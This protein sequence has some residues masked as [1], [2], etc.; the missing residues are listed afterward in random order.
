[1]YCDQ[2][3]SFEEQFILTFEV[4]SFDSL[5]HGLNEAFISKLQL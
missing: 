1:M 4:Y 5:Q 3:E 2:V